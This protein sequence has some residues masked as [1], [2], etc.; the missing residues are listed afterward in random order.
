[1]RRTGFTLIELLAVL[2]VIAILGMLS[3]P[4]ALAAAQRGSVNQFLVNLERIS[5]RANGDARRTPPPIDP[6]RVAHYGVVVVQNGNERFIALLKG[7]SITDS[8]IELANGLP[9]LQLRI[10][11]GV[12][13]LSDS[14]GVLA[15]LAGRIGWFY[16]Y[17]DGAP[18]ALPSDQLAIG[19]GT[20]AQAARPGL[21]AAGSDYWN[22]APPL[23]AVAASPVCASLL[24]RV[25][26]AKT[27]TA[28][29]IY[30]NGMFSTTDAD[31][32]LLSAVAVP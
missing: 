1:M 16:R 21:K 12:E 24:V 28:I 30:Q 8:G 19:I 20:P 11:A 18:I 31:P 14:G 3:I 2:S 4:A 10:P 9:V 15:P 17:G 29:T 27:G 32:Q 13:I 25:K 7:T 26:G 5:A 22:F 23:P 6:T